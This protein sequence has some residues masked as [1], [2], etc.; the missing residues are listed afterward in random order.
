MFWRVFL[1]GE[2]WRTRSEQASLDDRRRAEVDP[3]AQANGERDHQGREREAD[4]V[5]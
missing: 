5:R 3:V 2:K 1:M 4:Q